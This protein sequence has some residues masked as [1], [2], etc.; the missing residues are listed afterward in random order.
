MQCG[1]RTA[2][3]QTLKGIN[4]LPHNGWTGRNSINV[5]NVDWLRPSSAGGSI[6]NW[7][8]ETW[9]LPWASIPWVLASACSLHTSHMSV[10]LWFMSEVLLH[11]SC[12]L[13][14]CKLRLRTCDGSLDA[15]T[16][17]FA[18]RCLKAW[19]RHLIVQIFTLP[20]TASVQWDFRRQWMHRTDVQLVP[21]SLRMA[22]VLPFLQWA[23]WS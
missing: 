11:S 17:H 6:S 2:V 14:C 12:A 23:T 19:S 10:Q 18:Q 20:S 9:I 21:R 3:Q 15:Y 7:W 5:R 4:P 1:L 8:A 22:V 13:G 16:I